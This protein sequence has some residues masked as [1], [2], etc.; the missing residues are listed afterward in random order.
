VERVPPSPEWDALIARHQA[1]LE[2]H[3]R[4]CGLP[5]V[6][7]AEPAPEAPGAAGPAPMAGMLGGAERSDDVV[8]SVSLHYGDPVRYDGPHV[9]IRTS[10]RISPVDL[11]D[12]LEAA[13]DQAGDGSVVT[14]RAEDATVL[15]DGERRPATLLRAGARF[16]AVRFAHA[17][18]EVI[19]VA[20]DLAVAETPLAS[21]PDV[22]PFLRRRARYVASMRGIVPRQ[23]PPPD[24]EDPLRALVDAVLDDV[25][26]IRERAR[27][28]RRPRPGRAAHAAGSLWEPATRA[29]MRRTG[30][31][32]AAAND[33]VTA[34]VNQLIGLLEHA[35]WFGD[36]RLR[37]A[38]VEESL[39]YW[40]GTDPD[41]PSRT[42]QAAWRR[43]WDAKQVRGAGPPADV[44]TWFEQLQSGQQA[45]LDAW[46]EWSRHRP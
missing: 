7:L 28:G 34:L 45:W 22:E 12:A 20:R 6:G 32:Y 43:H 2:A 21:V 14:G 29:Q 11:R 30:Q 9:E 40:T 8:T 38:A 5:L 4:G 33:A 18:C 35:S 13:L 24:V 39:A 46:V 36:E 27:D 19:V 26:R 44:R 10:R 3:V 42:A 25:R 23:P 41:V 31:T 37:A 15:V 1:E 17:D 16:W